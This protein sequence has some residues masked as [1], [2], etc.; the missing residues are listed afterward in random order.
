MKDNFI[1]FVKNNPSLVDY[2]RKNNVS[3]QSLYEVYSFYGEDKNIWNKYLN[4][5]DSSIDE[6]VNMI[7][8]VNLES[9]RKVVDGLQKTLSLVQDIGGKNEEVKYEKRPVYE[10]LDD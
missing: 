4:N 3:W 8:S 6:L 7:R 5:K 9:I 10:D 2:V 1:K